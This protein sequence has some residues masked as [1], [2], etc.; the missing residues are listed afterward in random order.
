MSLGLP[1]SLQYSPMFIL[2]SSLLRLCDF[3]HSLANL[4]TLLLLSQTPTLGGLG[5]ESS[6]TTSVVALCACCC[7]YVHFPPSFPLV[8]PNPYLPHSQGWTLNKTTDRSGEQEEQEQ[9]RL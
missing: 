4:I 2:L 1:F 8:L 7:Q 9:G 3:Y 6:P 5:A